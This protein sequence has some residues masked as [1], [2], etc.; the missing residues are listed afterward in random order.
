MTTT[1]RPALLASLPELFAAAGY[2]ADH[3]NLSSDP[4]VLRGEEDRVEAWIVEIET[5]LR[6]RGEDEEKRALLGALRT[7]NA[8]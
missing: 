6:E 5:A 8:S 1:T 4:G 7:L 2:E 3:G